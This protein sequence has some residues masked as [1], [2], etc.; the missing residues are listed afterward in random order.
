[1]TL[2]KTTTVQL[3]WTP[4]HAGLQGNEAADRLAKEGAKEAAAMPE[5]SRITTIQ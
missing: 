1:M 5:D 4:G 2:S 3:L